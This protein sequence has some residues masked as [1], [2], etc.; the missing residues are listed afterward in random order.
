MLYITCVKSYTITSLWKFENR[1]E[2]APPLG[3][4]ICFKFNPPIEQYADLRKSRYRTH[5]GE[6]QPPPLFS[7]RWANKRCQII[8]NGRTEHV[9]TSM[10]LRSLFRRAKHNQKGSPRL[11]ARPIEDECVTISFWTQF[12][13]KAYFDIRFWIV[14]P[15]FNEFYITF[16]TFFLAIKIANIF[17]KG[18]QKFFGFIQR[19]SIGRRMCCNKPWWPRSRHGTDLVKSGFTARTE[20]LHTLLFTHKSSFT[21]VYPWLG[22]EPFPHEGT[23]WPITDRRNEAVNIVIN[24]PFNL[25][26]SFLFKEKRRLAFEVY[27]VSDIGNFGG[28][29]LLLQGHNGSHRLT[30]TIDKL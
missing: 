17:W 6:F 30:S 7:E 24:W 11:T 28:K 14:E 5:I 27:F 15:F 4:W 8:A 3:W 22:C 20:I 10:Y 23:G 29:P 26:Y 25:F 19:G 16:G 12:I 13:E 18:L 2:I 9:H 1:W 21:T